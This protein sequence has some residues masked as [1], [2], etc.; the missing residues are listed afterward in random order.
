M[1]MN[2]FENQVSKCF[3]PSVECFALRRGQPLTQRVNGFSFVIRME[4]VR[5]KW[6]RNASDV[7]SFPKGRIIKDL[8]VEIVETVLKCFCFLQNTSHID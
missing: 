6:W 1:S 3:P 2:V 7:W 8:R 5:S 4:T